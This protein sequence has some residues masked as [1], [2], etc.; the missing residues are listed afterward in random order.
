MSEEEKTDKQKWKSLMAEVGDIHKSTDKATEDWKNKYKSQC[1]VWAERKAIILQMLDRMGIPTKT[2][3]QVNLAFEE[4]LRMMLDKIQNGGALDGGL[5][6]SKLHAEELRKATTVLDDLG[7]PDIGNSEDTAPLRVAERIKTMGGKLNQYIE[8]MGTLKTRQKTWGK[9]MGAVGMCLGD[10]LDNVLSSINKVLEDSDVPAVGDGAV[11]TPI[12]RMRTALLIL[13]NTKS[14]MEEVDKVLDEYGVERI[15]RGQSTRLR[16]TLGRLRFNA[17][18]A[19]D[20]VFG[21]NPYITEYEEM[22]TAWKHTTPLGITQYWAIA[23]IG[24][25]KFE[26]PINESTY[27]ELMENE[28][29]LH[30]R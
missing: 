16:D 13:N 5:A 19:V 7:V 15:E 17:A 9:Y 24:G 23:E 22:K 21:S 4:R 14:E 30:R 2:D 26:C 8:D 28:D 1:G 29:V 10:P 6:E 27:N 3:Q 11:M 18:A 12:A 25:E 20:K